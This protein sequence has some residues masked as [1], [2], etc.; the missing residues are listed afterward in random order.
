[1][2]PIRRQLCTRNSFPLVQGTAEK[3]S[4]HNKYQI[5]FDKKKK[6]IKNLL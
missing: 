6:K 2:H 1:M 5:N 4:V 3:K